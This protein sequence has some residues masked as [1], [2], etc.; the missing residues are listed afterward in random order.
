MKDFEGLYTELL[1]AILY[2]KLE[3]ISPYDHR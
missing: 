2:V 3:V 1:L